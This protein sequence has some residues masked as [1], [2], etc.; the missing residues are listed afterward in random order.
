MSTT[1]SSIWTSELY[2]LSF[3]FS[4][5]H[6]SLHFPFSLRWYVIV[7]RR[8]RASPPPHPP[9]HPRHSTNFHLL[10]ALSFLLF[11]VVTFLRDLDLG[12]ELGFDLDDEDLEGDI[13]EE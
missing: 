10:T 12:F 11:Y 8:N 5:I 7:S 2:S 1:T 4:I 6:H 13:D 3:S 9:R